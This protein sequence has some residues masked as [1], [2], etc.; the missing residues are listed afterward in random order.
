MQQLQPPAPPDPTAP[1]TVSSLQPLAPPDP[2]AP[3]TVSSLQPLAPPDPTAP[4]TVSSDSS[5]NSPVPNSSNR[6]RASIA[7]AP[8]RQ[9]RSASAS[10]KD[11]SSTPVSERRTGVDTPSSKLM[12]SDGS[13]SSDGDSDGNNG[14]S[15][16]SDS[17][18]FLGNTFQAATS[19]EALD[20]L[21]RNLARVHV[22]GHV[23]CRNSN[24]RKVLV[25]CK[26]CD[27]GATVGLFRGHTW[28]LR[29]MRE[30]ASAPC[31]FSD[32][33]QT[34][35]ACLDSTRKAAA[36]HHQSSSINRNVTASSVAGTI[37]SNTAPSLNCTSCGWEFEGVSKKFVSCELND[38]HKFCVECFSD[39]VKQSVNGAGRNAFIDSG[40][41]NC[42]F[43]AAPTS[44]SRDY[45]NAFNMRI[46]SQYLDEQLYE[47][48]VSGLSERHVI[49]VQMEYEE[50]LKKAVKAVPNNQTP[51]L[52]IETV[53]E[54]Q[55]F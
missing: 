8:T 45:R 4:I 35:T 7:V 42:P 1:I 2:T 34:E 6:K 22:G 48:Y 21:L 31:K 19:S 25:A 47:R 9:L 5:D 30:G 33:E 52:Q 36:A 26:L 46:C 10:M 43:C 32:K 51:D 39:A 50:R 27:A 40:F 11:A 20:W 44:R 18:F 14:V 54:C 17:V 28:T 55:C 13:T 53:G 16:T 12:D 15:G 29:H 3:I 24:F 23:A 38:K 41:I 49:R 37:K